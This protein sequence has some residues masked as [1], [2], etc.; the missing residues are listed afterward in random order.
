[1]AEGAAAEGRSEELPDETVEGLLEASTVA[2]RQWLVCLSSPGCDLPPEGRSW[3]PSIPLNA[4]ALG[5]LSF[6]VA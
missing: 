6:P 5:D 1:M 4:I 2:Q 3:F